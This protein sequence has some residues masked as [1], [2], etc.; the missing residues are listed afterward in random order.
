[1]KRRENKPFTKCTYGAWWTGD[2]S[3]L[4]VPTSNGAI[5][6]SNIQKSRFVMNLQR[7]HP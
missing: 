3:S 4:L 5:H 7:M 6:S 2:C 1:M